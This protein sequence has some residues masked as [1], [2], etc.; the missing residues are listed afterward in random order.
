MTTSAESLSRTNEPLVFDVHR[1]RQDF[2]V[3]HQQVKGKSLVYLDNGATTQ[4]PWA[5]IDAV[6]EYYR[7]SNANVH[8][9][10]HALSERAS[11]GGV[12]AARQP[13][14]RCYVATLSPPLTGSPR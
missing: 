1:I 4:K 11:G 14:E 8:R 3:L 13:L 6:A 10:V 12:I 2:P 9:G 5:V 7:Q